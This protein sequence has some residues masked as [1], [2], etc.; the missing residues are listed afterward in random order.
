[1]VKANGDA[2]GR[3]AGVCAYDPTATE[4]LFLL[5]RSDHCFAREG[6]NREEPSRR[7]Q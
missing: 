4:L 7:E 6:S 5:R 2:S 3:H 1:M